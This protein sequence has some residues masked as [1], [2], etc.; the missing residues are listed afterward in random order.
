MGNK[1]DEK[2]IE[3]QIKNFGSNLR[4]VG[5]TI[6]AGTMNLFHNRQLL[7]IKPNIDQNVLEQ[8]IGKK[9]EDKTTE[10]PIE[11]SGSNVTQITSYSGHK[12]YKHEECEENPCE[13]KQYEK[14]P[15][16]MSLT[17]QLL[18]LSNSLTFYNSTHNTLKS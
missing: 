1:C 13:F 15:D 8:N 16:L 5:T 18:L 17:S 12:Y 3:N 7:H 6:A 14:F 11:N 10:D 4:F 9:W 2:N